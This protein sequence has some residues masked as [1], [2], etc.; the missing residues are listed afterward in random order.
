MGRTL[1]SFSPCLGD[2]LIPSEESCHVIMILDGALE[3]CMFSSHCCCCHP[4]WP[5]ES[6]LFRS[7]FFICISKKSPKKLKQKRETHKNKN[8]PQTQK[9]FYLH[10]IYIIAWW[11]TVFSWISS[12]GA[13]NLTV[14]CKYA[15][16]SVIWTLWFNRLIA[17]ISPVR[18]AG[19][20][21]LE[22]KAARKRKAGCWSVVTGC[23]VSPIVVILCI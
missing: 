14:C 8:N 7:Q 17:S 6:Y 20:F 23:W 12:I 1:T 16:H 3:T 22:I 15:L 18:M 13:V 21:W 2:F 5:R 19:F 4:V 10:R 9:Y 11:D